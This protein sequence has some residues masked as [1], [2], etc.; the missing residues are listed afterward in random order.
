MGVI[1]NAP[2]AEMD[3][4]VKREC[5]A[6]DLPDIALINIFKISLTQAKNYND[7]SKNGSNLN[8]T[9]LLACVCVRW[10][11]LITE[12]DPDECKLVPYV[13]G[14]IGNL[15]SSISFDRIKSIAHP[16]LWNILNDKYPNQATKEWGWWRGSLLPPITT[17]EEQ[18]KSAI[19]FAKGGHL[20]L[21][22]EVIK[23]DKSLARDL[24][25]L[26]H[27]L[28]GETC[29]NG[30]LEV[31]KYLTDPAGPVA[32]TAADA[33]VN[34]NNALRWACANCHLEVVKY[35]T[36]PAGP[37]ALTDVTEP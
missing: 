23:R 19:Q 37:V 26:K 7:N 28:F 36:S 25:D 30:H 4:L 10:R 13:L 18:I 14:L 33:R 29:A 1:S 9:L 3:T 31:V 5:S 11:N 6:N 34:D 32:L 20:Y 21:L 12:L 27:G 17:R 22:Q 15:P 16:S 35:L 2:R 24:R 8:T